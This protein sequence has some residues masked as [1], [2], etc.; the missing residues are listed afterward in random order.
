MDNSEKKQSDRF[1]QSLA[2]ELA[3]E[4]LIEQRRGRRWGIFF[5]SLLALYLFGLLFFYIGQDL[6]MGGFS[7]GKHSALIDING[8]IAANREARADFVVTGL[9]SA[10]EDEN[11]EGVILRINSPGG[12]AVQAGY[13]NDEINRLREKHPDIPVYAVIGDICAS[14]GYYIA[15][16]ADEIYANKASLVGSIGVVMA[17]FG[18]ADALDKLGVERRLLHAGENKGFMDPFQP[19]KDTDQAHAQTLLDEIH[20]QFIE[21]VKQG[22]GDRLTGADETLFSGLIWS[23]QESVE[24]GLV[25]GL[26]SASQVARDIIGAADIVDFTRREDY[27][28]RFARNMGLAFF[29]SLDSGFELR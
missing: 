16:A 9:R 10:F 21:V 26:A 17:G 13:I 4:F 8:M 1:N 24:L 12:S 19:L 29:R 23:G 11:T 20:G 5:K 18:F 28:G 22:R 6:E 27:L 7:K 14:G 15:A 3:R 25:D 2:N